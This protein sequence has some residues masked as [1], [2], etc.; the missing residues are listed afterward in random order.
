MKECKPV[1]SF[2]YFTVIIKHTA[3]FLQYSRGQERF[4]LTFLDKHNRG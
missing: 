4:R 1:K 3:V 2:K